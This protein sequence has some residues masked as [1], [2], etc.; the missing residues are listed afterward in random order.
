LNR[1]VST[2]GLAAPGLVARHELIEI[3]ARQLACLEREALV[4][5]EVIYPQ[6]LRPRL[7]RGFLA[8]EEQ[9]VGL[10]AA[11]IEDARRQPQQRVDIA[12]VEQLAPHRLTGATLEQYVVGHHDRRVP[13]RLEKRTNMLEEVELLVGGRCPEV[14]TEKIPSFETRGTPRRSAVA[15]IQRSALC[16]RCP[17]A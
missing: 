1:S 10:D 14:F 3:R 13:V 7:L 4:G 17:S 16:S 5:A 6:L 12:L 9:D 11:G 2:R 15:A 8:V